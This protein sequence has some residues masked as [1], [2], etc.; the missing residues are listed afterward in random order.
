MNWEKLKRTMGGGPPQIQANK[1]KKRGGGPRPAIKRPTA[2]LEPQIKKKK[3]H[4]INT[5]HV[6]V[7]GHPHKK[8]LPKKRTT[9]K[10]PR[11]GA[12]A[13][14]DLWDPNRHTETNAYCDVDA[15][16]GY[17]TRL[18]RRSTAVEAALVKA[19]SSLG[20]SFQELCAKRLGG[21]KWFAHFEQWLWARRGA[22]AGGAAGAMPVL[23]SGPTAVEDP[24]LA[25]KLVRAGAS[26]AD[27]ATA[28]RR[29]GERSIALLRDV[30]RVDAAAG[31]SEVTQGKE[32]G[33]SNNIVLSSRGVDVCIRRD[34]LEKLRE[35]HQ[36]CSQSPEGDPAD[37]LNA[38]F[39]V[40]ARYHSLQGGNPRNGGMQA[41]LH[42]QV[43]D[44]LAEDFDC[45]AECFASPLNCRWD[46]YCSASVDV[47]QPF[48]SLGSF[49]DFSPIR[50]SFE[51]NPVNE[52][53]TYY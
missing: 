13:S 26:E 50:G 49:F 33:G 37:F 41:A 18:P 32:E 42:P 25:G 16:S 31:P 20:T 19:T 12:A 7:K 29:L 10:K 43:F 39:T 5:L 9:P 51:A 34:H 38:A 4:T 44:A 28:C 3:K 6:D 27:A 22:E 52:S 47:D 11:P 14:T 2:A 53:K 48:G 17:L 23:P 46:R 24:E 8:M 1:K 40:V 36:R 21:R 15:V 35:L 45:T 30:G